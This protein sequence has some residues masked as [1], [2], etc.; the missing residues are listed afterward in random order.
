[1]KILFN[2]KTILQHS[3]S[4]CGESEQFHPFSPDALVS[5]IALP[6]YTMCC[7]SPEPLNKQVCPT[8][9]IFVSTKILAEGDF[10]TATF[11]IARD[12]IPA[13]YQVRDKLQQESR[14]CPCEGR[15]PLF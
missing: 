5:M 8:D 9:A 11:I 3:P 7:L 4:L 10:Y 6:P 1:M 12:V 14:H 2:K 13:P 15:E